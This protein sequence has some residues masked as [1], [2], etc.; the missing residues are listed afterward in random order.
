MVLSKFFPSSMVFAQYGKARLP[1]VPLYSRVLFNDA[2]EFTLCYDLHFCSPCFWQVLYPP[3]QY[4][5][6]L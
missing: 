2:A 6:L 3:A 5:T 4:P 1:F